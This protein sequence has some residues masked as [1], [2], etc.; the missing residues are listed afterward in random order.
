ML[1]IESIKKC[2]IELS[3]N[4]EQ[5]QNEIQQS[6]AYY[7]QLIDSVKQNHILDLEHRECQY[8]AIIASLK[9]QLQ[10]YWG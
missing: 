2:N 7:N 9:S 6:R 10:Q 4:M 3:K 8:E 5:M 1:K